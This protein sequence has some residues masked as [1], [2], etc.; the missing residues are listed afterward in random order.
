MNQTTANNKKIDIQDENLTNKFSNVLSG[1][2]SRYGNRFVVN[3][4]IIS[5]C[6]CNYSRIFQISDMAPTLIHYQNSLAWLLRFVLC[7]E[8]YSVHINEMNKISVIPSVP[9]AK[10][11][12]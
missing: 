10:N 7:Y 4:I 5:N 11:I 9:Y 12:L 3:T 2:Y 8:L 6:W 1:T